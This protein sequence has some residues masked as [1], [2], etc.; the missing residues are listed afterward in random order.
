MER[1]LIDKDALIRFLEN[2]ASF[3]SKEADK[4]FE[5]YDCCEYSAMCARVGTLE[6]IVMLLKTEAPF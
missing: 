5:D 1:N 6:A 4:K 2:E 3:W